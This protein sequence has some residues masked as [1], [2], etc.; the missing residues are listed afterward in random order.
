MS[1][2]YSTKCYELFVKTKK[3]ITYL[4]NYNNNKI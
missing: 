3:K 2:T 1:C 4:I